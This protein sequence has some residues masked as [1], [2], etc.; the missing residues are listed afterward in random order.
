MLEGSRLLDAPPHHV[1]GDQTIELCK[2]Y[3]FLVLFTST[4]GFPGDIRLA[5]AI[6]QTNPN[7]K[8]AFVG[9]HVTTSARRIIEDVRGNRFRR[10]QR[11]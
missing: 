11:V 7:I 10:A 2:E 1:S 9:P 6:K 8:I 3:E 4:P 5:E